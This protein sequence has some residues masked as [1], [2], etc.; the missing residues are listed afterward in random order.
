MWLRGKENK[1]QNLGGE[2]GHGFVDEVDIY[3]RKCLC[4]NYVIPEAALS[5]LKGIKFDYQFFLCVSSEVIY[6]N[7]K[8]RI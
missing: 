1:K 2:G 3:Q 5:I 8:R 7:W 6:Q 4:E